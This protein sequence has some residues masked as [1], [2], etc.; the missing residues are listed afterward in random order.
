MSSTPTETGI[1]AYKERISGKSEKS[2]LDGMYM[3][4][5]TISH[6]T[7]K[8]RGPEAVGVMGQGRGD[9]RDKMRLEPFCKYP[10]FDNDRVGAQ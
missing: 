5:L 6:Q 3:N 9:V 2:S 4:H 1:G 8:E 10:G 7:D